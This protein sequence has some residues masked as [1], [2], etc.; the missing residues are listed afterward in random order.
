MDSDCPDG[1]TFQSLYFSTKREPRLLFGHHTWNTMTQLILNV[2]LN[3][4]GLK[5][6]NILIREDLELP[7][8]CFVLRMPSDMM[9]GD[10]PTATA[11]NSMLYICIESYRE[12]W[13]QIAIRIESYWKRI[14]TA[15]VIWDPVSYKRVSYIKKWVYTLWPMMKICF[16]RH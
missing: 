7:L 3:I 6:V 15:L 14:V 2:N 1:T 11:V 4:F 9:I 12:S 5:D 13:L 10:R 8:A 16:V